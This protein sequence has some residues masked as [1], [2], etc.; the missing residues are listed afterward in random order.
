M[1][2]NPENI[3]DTREQCLE[4]LR[5]ALSKASRGELVFHLPKPEGIRQLMSKGHFHAH[6]EFFLQVSG[7]V[8]FTFPQS[9]LT[10][11]A[12]EILMIPSWLCHAERSSCYKTTSNIVVMMTLSEIAWHLAKTVAPEKYATSGYGYTISPKLNLL[13]NMCEELTQLRHSSG[14][15]DKFVYSA[16]TVSTLHLLEEILHNA[17]KQPH[18]MNHKITTCRQ[19]INSNLANSKLNVQY[20]AERLGCNADYLSHLFLTK[21]GVPLTEFI[22]NRRIQVAIG[23]LNSENMNISEVAYSCGYSDPGYFSR[24]F[25]KITGKSPGEFRK[26][27]T[28]QPF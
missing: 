21:V 18:E 7:K 5:E 4:L 1:S 26:Q 25:K 15:Y 3:L 11:N 9:R 2:D 22:N 12:G 6:P 8:T 20:L 17:G 19:L 13:L 27:P 10:L 14:R 16:M 24:V 23:L 28:G